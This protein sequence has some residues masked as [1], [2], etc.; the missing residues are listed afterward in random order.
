V[1]T[2][3][4]PSFISNIEI[5]RYQDFWKEY[6][7]FKT[8]LT[9]I[10]TETECSEEEDFVLVQKENIQEV[11]EGFLKDEKNRHR[12][13]QA[14]IPTAPCQNVTLARIFNFEKVCQFLRN[15]SSSK[16]A[17]LKL[18]KFSKQSP[19]Y[20]VSDEEQEDTFGNLDAVSAQYG[21]FSEPDQ[22]RP[23]SFISMCKFQKVP[24]VMNL[25]NCDLFRRSFT[26]KGLGF[27]FNNDRSDHLYKKKKN[28]D[29]QMKTFYFNNKVD[30]R[31]IASA[32][33]D[34]SLRLIL[35]NNIEEVYNF[36]R[37]KSPTNPPGEIK[38]KPKSVDIVLHD[39]SH[40]A[41]MRTKR[42]QARLSPEKIIL[43]FSVD[44]A[45]P[46]L[47]GVRDAQRDR[48]RHL[49]PVPLRGPERLQ[50]EGG[51]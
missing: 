9:F 50:A 19:V 41:N 14:D 24:E 1:M 31:M 15:I 33:P 8:K 37:T 2:D 48:D 27:T 28:I 5:Q 34:E 26:N 7:N 3:T 47:H 13:R 32:N 23:N 11:A 39:P 44:P 45:G 38:F 6:N 25:N 29:L 43:T 20:Q 51:E 30:P 42:I 16:E 17:I 40:P 21:Y 12:V 22:S 4:L 46:V 10:C 35:E 18:L 49:R 36:E